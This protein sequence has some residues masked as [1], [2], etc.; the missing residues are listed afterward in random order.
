MTGLT[1]RPGKVD[2]EMQP[3]LRQEGAESMQ[4]EQYEAHVRLHAAGGLLLPEE[5]GRSIVVLAL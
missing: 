5:P 1:L 4:T 2:T 3:L